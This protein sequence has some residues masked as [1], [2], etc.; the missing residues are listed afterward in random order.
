MKVVLIA[1]IEIDILIGQNPAIRQPSKYCLPI[2]LRVSLHFGC[3]LFCISMNW[4]SKSLALE[5]L[6]E[7]SEAPFQSIQVAF[8]RTQLALVIRTDLVDFYVPF[9]FDKRKD[10]VFSIDHCPFHSDCLGPLLFGLS[11]V[12]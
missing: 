9:S 7:F 6:I 2:A 12:S 4:N 11:P 5:N 8:R 10:V 3:L 1:K